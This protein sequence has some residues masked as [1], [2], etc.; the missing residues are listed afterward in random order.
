MRVNRREF[1]AAGAALGAAACA[2]TGSG[3]GGSSAG[4]LFYLGGAKVF[5]IDP[6]GGAPK[7]LVDRTAENQTNRGLND[8]IALD[9]KAGHIYWTNMGRAAEND[10]Y[11]MRAKLDGSEVTEIVP[12]GGCWTPKQCKLDLAGRKIYWS[13]REGMA[14]SRCNLDGTG[15]ERIVATG[16]PVTAKGQQQLWCVGIALDLQRRQVYWTQKGGDNAGEGLIRRCSMD[17]PHGATFTNRNDVV[18]LF[19]RLPEPIDLE[20]DTSKRQMYW[21]DRGDNTI[22]RA[23]MDPAKNYDPAKRID[24]T[25]LLRGLKE[26][27]GISLDLK[28]GRMAYTSLGGEVGVAKIDGTG[29]KML[30]TEQ[31]ALTGIAWG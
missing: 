10:G 9:L 21:T 19:S 5:S 13:D 4:H 7:T 6:A 23:P 1:V 2:S 15:V 18:T 3:G 30:A 29:A 27:I 22:N 20:L 12:P 26:A 11:I 31:G 25:V 24:K 14:V 16:N 8:G 17:M 28:H